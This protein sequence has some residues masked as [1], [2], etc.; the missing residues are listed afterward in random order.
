MEHLWIRVQ[1]YRNKI[2]KMR[3]KLKNKA[4]TRMLNKS[5]IMY[6]VYHQLVALKLSQGE[7]ILPKKE[8]QILQ[9]CRSRD[10][11]KNGDEQIQQ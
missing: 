4:L 2:T 8:T 10:L 1:F 5:K 11:L 9:T 6:T 7:S 3:K